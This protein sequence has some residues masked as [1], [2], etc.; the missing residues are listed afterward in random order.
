MGLFDKVKSSLSGLRPDH[1]AVLQEHLGPEQLLAYVGVLPSATETDRSGDRPKDLTE[2]A[3]GAAH[4]L[5]DKVVKDR[6]VGGAEGSI[7]QS[8]PRSTDPVMLAVAEHS[9]SVWQFGLGSRATSPDLVVRVPREQV[10]SIADTGKRGARGHVRLTFTDE[11]FFDYQTLTAPSA[12]FW[13]A[14][15]TFGA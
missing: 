2:L 3:Q 7:G 11:S 12:Q 13:S 15:E 5:T 1:A 10:A 9:V 8:M 14:T 4:K 6:H